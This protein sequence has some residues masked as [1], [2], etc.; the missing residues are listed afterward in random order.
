MET[1]ENPK[2]VMTDKIID[3]IVKS[4]FWSLFFFIRLKHNVLR[5]FSSYFHDNFS[6]ALRHLT[7]PIAQV[8]PHRRIVILVFKSKEEFAMQRENSLNI[9]Q[10]DLILVLWHGKSVGRRKLVPVLGNII[11]Y[12]GES[13]ALL[14]HTNQSNN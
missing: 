1:T 7:V 10:S 2:E 9:L 11:E 13:T 8:K 14:R 6:I 5:N 12:K 4:N 3:L